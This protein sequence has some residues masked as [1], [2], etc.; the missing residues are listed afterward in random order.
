MGASGAAYQ[1][2]MKSNGEAVASLRKNL[3][4]KAGDA[5][6]GDAKTLVDN[7]GH[8]R[9]YWQQKNVADAV[10]FA[11]DAQ[12]GFRN[13]SQLAAAGNLTTLPLHD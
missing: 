1:G 2:W 4:A 8:V 7:F 13:V 12:S 9:E 11:T 10:K 6:A 3:D 5:A